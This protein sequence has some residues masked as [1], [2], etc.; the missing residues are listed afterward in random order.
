MFVE[1]ELQ[2]APWT[3]TQNFHLFKHARESIERFSRAFH[4]ASVDEYSFEGVALPTCESALFTPQ[5][6]CYKPRCR[7]CASLLLTVDFN[8]VP[9]ELISSAQ[10]RWFDAEMCAR[11]LYLSCTTAPSLVANCIIQRT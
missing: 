4:F 8:P 9:P 10:Y 2:L 6:G 11:V 5:R 3:L 1:E 7:L